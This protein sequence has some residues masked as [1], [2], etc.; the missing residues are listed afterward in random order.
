[1]PRPVAEGCT[2][3]C[4]CLTDKAFVGWHECCLLKIGPDCYRVPSFQFE[5][6]EAVM[7]GRVSCIA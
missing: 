5:A 3:A 4:K 2:R 6:T 1:M 7:H